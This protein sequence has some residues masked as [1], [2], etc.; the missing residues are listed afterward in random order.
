MIKV[1]IAEDNEILRDNVVKKLSKEKD[2]QVVGN[3][4]S[5]AGI[6]ELAKNHEFDIAV[7]DVEM[8]RANAGIIAAG[9][10]LGIKED[11]KIIFLTVHEDNQTIL[12]AIDVG[13]VDYVV[14]SDKTETLVEHIRNAYE[15]KVQM[16]NLITTVVSDEYRRLR[17]VETGLLFFIKNISVL[18][19]TEKALL[20]LL[21]EKKT[22]S[23]IAQIRFVEI[24]TI[25]TQ[26]ASILKKLKERRTKDIIK[27]IEELNLQS[28][29]EEY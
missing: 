14:K 4:N 3:A 19:P 13:A 24:S 5:G 26:I 17:K 8:E 18:T 29:L 6:V 16:D 15:N 2:I 9:E 21:L 25:K 10:I 7:L 28:L 27:K 22:V 1:L 20:K 12:N 23:Q 11:A